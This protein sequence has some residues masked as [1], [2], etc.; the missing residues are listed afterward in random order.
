LAT[1]NHRKSAVLATASALSRTRP[2]SKAYSM[3]TEKPINPI[4]LDEYVERII[5]AA[6][7]RL[8][9][10]GRISS[11]DREDWEQDLRLAILSSAAGFDP[12][13]AGWHTYANAVVRHA[14]QFKVREMTAA[15]RNR[16]SCQS[17]DALRASDD[18]GFDEPG[19]TDD[20]AGTE[21]ADVV[22]AA[23]AT[24]AGDER[25]LAE[26]LLQMPAM[27]TMR[28]LGWSR[29]RFYKARD[30]V[31]QAFARTSAPRTRSRE[32]IEDHRKY[33]E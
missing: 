2:F 27:E 24:L 28:Y 20:R 25:D 18:H 32:V 8:M 15:C 4:G 33:K 9:R 6:V 14:V 11:S 10:R 3:A 5:A 7:V 12:T 30:G 31:Q 19:M 23:I 29:R 16:R 17:L 21:T 1:C 22:H 13:R 26:A